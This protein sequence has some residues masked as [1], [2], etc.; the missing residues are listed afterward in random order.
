MD[1]PSRTSATEEHHK[2]RREKECNRVIRGEL[3]ACIIPPRDSLFDT[4][5][6]SG[7]AQIL[8]DSYKSQNS[9]HTERRHARHWAAAWLHRAPPSRPRLLVPR[10]LGL[11]A[12]RVSASSQCPRVLPAPLH[13]SAAAAGMFFPPLPA[14]PPAVLTTPTRRGQA[15]GRTAASQPTP[16]RGGHHHHQQVRPNRTRVDL[17]AAARINCCP[18]QRALPWC[19]Q[20]A[21]ARS[22]LTCVCCVC[23]SLL[24]PRPSVHSRHAHEVAPPPPEDSHPTN[25]SRRRRRRSISSMSSRSCMRS[26]C[27]GEP[28]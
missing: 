16:Q 18:T 19:V 2:E 6:S 20:V 13:H 14:P 22:T 3:A 1:A 24:R 5:E 25:S 23:P 12:A 28:S 26:L 27:K 15:T 4:F 9:W 21:P 17:S 7:I 8:R 11:V 10:H